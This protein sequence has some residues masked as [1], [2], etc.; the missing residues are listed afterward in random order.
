MHFIGFKGD[1]YNR[2]KQIFGEPD[3]YHRHWDTRAKQE[4]A[5]GDVVVFAKGTERDKC[6]A[7]TFDDSAIYAGDVR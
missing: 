4:I 7:F 1:E 3:F 6:V 5:P 2:A